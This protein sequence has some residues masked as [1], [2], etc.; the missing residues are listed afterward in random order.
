[1]SYSG[2]RWLGAACG[3]TAQRLPSEQSFIL[4]PGTAGLKTIGF[5][6]RW[7]EFPP[8]FV[9]ILERKYGNLRRGDIYRLAEPIDLPVFHGASSATQ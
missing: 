4:V 8:L 7:P 1:V 6:Q 5:L 2:V 9:A 3:E